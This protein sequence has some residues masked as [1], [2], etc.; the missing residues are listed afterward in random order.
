MAQLIV[1]PCKW[2]FAL[3]TESEGS[4]PK[5]CAGAIHK[6]NKRMLN[7]AKQNFSHENQIALSFVIFLSYNDIVTKFF[8]LSTKLLISSFKHNLPILSQ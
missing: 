5:G 6:V 4:S 3:S 8:R 1:M 7:N 2:S